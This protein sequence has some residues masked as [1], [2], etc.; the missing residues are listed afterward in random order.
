MVSNTDKHSPQSIKVEQ[1]IKKRLIINEKCLFLYKIG[2]LVKL[3]SLGSVD[4]GS[5]LKLDGLQNVLN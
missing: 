5:H 3:Y 1:L 4:C 2:L